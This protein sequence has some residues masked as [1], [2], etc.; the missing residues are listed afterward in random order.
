MKAG[1][2]NVHAVFFDIGDTLVYDHPPLLER[3]RSSLDICGFPYRADD[4]TA[5]FRAAEN[6]AMSEYLKGVPFDHPDVLAASSLIILDELG[7]RSLDRE[8]LL[9]LHDSFTA[10]E[11]RRV[12][13]E[14]ARGLLTEL[15]RRGFRIGAISD[16]EPTLPA[17]LVEL[18]IAHFFEAVA[19]S[20]IVGVTKPNPALFR[21]ALDQMSQSSGQPIAPD[22]SLHIGD[23]YELDVAGARSVGMHA[24]LFDWKMRTPRA[25]CPRVTSFDQM[26][27]ML[28]A[29]PSPAG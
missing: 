27:D 22:N 11:Y 24:L 17:L 12:V 25:D 18:D 4:L 20:A 28:L 13:H 9:L 7:I 29:L 14:G 8:Q 2:N 15:A 16:W 10:I 19:V 23:Y 1:M 6:Y 21:A 5:A 26:A 3:V